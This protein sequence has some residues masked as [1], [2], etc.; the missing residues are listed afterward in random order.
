MGTPSTVGA[1]SSNSTVSGASSTHSHAL[2]VTGNVSILTGTIAHGGTIPLPSGYTE[3]Q[4]KWVAIPSNMSDY[5]NNDMASF[6][7]TTSG[8]VVTVLVDGTAYAGNY[9]TYVIIGV[10]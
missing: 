9:A 7:V 10:K 2:D 3:A 4:C 6:Q 5:G 1:G 8:R